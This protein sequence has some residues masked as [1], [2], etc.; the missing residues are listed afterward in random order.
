MT[1]WVML[2]WVEGIKAATHQGSATK[3]EMA[4]AKTISGF[5]FNDLTYL[6]SENYCGTRVYNRHAILG[7]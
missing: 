6:V 4:A 1:E 3:H 7:V 2:Y 5:F